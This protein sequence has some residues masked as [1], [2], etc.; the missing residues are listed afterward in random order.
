M[1]DADANAETLRTYEQAAQLYCQR[2]GRSDEDG[3]LVELVTATRRVWSWVLEIGSGPGID[4]ALLEER[5]FRVRRTDA[6]ASFVEMLRA[7]GHQADVLDVRT[8]DRGGPYDAVLAQAVLLH[9]DRAELQ[10]VLA[11]LSAAVRPDG[12]LALSLKE[13]DGEEWSNHKVDLPRHFV[14]WREE[15]LRAALT[16]AGWQPMVLEHLATPHGPWLLSLSRRRGGRV[17]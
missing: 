5:G 11:R 16:I 17:A 10:R 15:P 13:G 7:Q 12:L 1:T 2:T 9:I 6:T 8:D 14:Y 3:G 4:A